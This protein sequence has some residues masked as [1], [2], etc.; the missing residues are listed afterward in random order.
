M[1]Y[2]LSKIYL[3]SINHVLG[4]IT[5]ENNLPLIPEESDTVIRA[6]P[7]AEDEHLHLLGDSQFGTPEVEDLHKDLHAF[8]EPHTKSLPE[9]PAQQVSKLFNDCKLNPFDLT[10]V[11][12]TFSSLFLFPRKQKQYKKEGFLLSLFMV[13]WALLFLYEFLMQL[14]L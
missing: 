10:L 13:Q 6:D 2:L 14:P 7:P 8:Q 9:E 12:L 4:C 3:P 1:L 5:V 11:S